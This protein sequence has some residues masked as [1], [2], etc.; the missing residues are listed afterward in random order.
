MHKFIDFIKKR[1][2]T[3]V[4]VSAAAICGMLSFG[5]ISKSLAYLTDAETMNNVV[6]IGDVE[7]E[8]TEPNWPGNNSDTVKNQLGNQ[9]TP[10]NPTIKN[11]GT[12]DA[13]VFLRMTVPVAEVT[14]VSDTG[15]LGTKARQELYYFKKTADTAQTH[16]NNFYA[17][18]IELP[19]K[20]TGTDMSAATRTYVFG[21]KTRVT[22]NQSTDPLFDKIQ[23]KNL[24]EGSLPSKTSESIKL[25]AFAIQADEVISGDVVDTTGNMDAEALTKVYTI[26]V[27]QNNK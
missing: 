15:T 17:D 20:E 8:L 9:E 7:M 23:L 13:V 16:A 22:A 3:I 14:P 10:K 19:T 25:E 26:Y 12:N 6:T 24:L 2:K 21:Y 11:T 1:K 18:W 5:G 4:A 27:T